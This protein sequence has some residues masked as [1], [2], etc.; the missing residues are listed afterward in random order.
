MLSMTPDEHD[1]LWREGARWLHDLQGLE[2]F[3]EALAEVGRPPASVAA[4]EWR[5]VRAYP[6]PHA[7]ARLTADAVPERT[8]RDA[9]SKPQRR[10]DVHY[11]DHSGGRTWMLVRRTPYVATVHKWMLERQALELAKR[12]IKHRC[13]ERAEGE[14]GARYCYVAYQ[15]PGPCDEQSLIEIDAYCEKVERFSKAYLVESEWA[16]ALVHNALVHDTP[17]SL[18]R[19]RP[20]PYIKAQFLLKVDIE[21]GRDLRLAEL[22][23]LRDKV[24]EEIQKAEEAQRAEKS[25]EEPAMSGL[26]ASRDG[27]WET[28][29]K[30]MQARLLG[31]ATTGP[32]RRAISD[33]RDYL[34]AAA[35]GAPRA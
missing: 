22:R 9:L 11:V 13:L 27:T 31:A 28:A 3:R 26:R 4:H 12:R 29:L 15:D 25:H 10:D 32:Q 6:N 35:T 21:P 2:G 8:A 17:L 24:D 16:Y 33:V 7:Y 19:T 30:G 1:V 34:H 23:Y 5:A 18:P 20:E 14:D